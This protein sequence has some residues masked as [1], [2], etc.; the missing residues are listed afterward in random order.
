M[1]KKI[2]KNNTLTK[3]WLCK[4]SFQKNWLER[5]ELLLNL[6]IDNEIDCGYRYK[7]AEFGCGANAPFYT[8]C[9]PYDN[10][11]VD[12]YD[13]NK[14]DDATT[15]I[16]LN[17]PFKIDE[18]DVCVFSGVLEYLDDV[19]TVLSTILQ[20]SN[21]L[22]LSYAYLSFEAIATDVGFINA[23]KNR[24][25]VNGWRNHYTNHD[26]VNLLSDIGIISAITSWK[27]QT[28]FLVRN[29]KTEI[30]ILKL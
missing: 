10:F 4:E 30:N 23:I 5:S 18:Y 8:A 11:H 25:V 9:L 6:L 14:W 22:L 2:V 24:S 13:L 3:R 21:Y 19:K 26:M 15:V 20:S 1:N 12:K 17:K 28:L 27:N 16:N 7:F 29:P